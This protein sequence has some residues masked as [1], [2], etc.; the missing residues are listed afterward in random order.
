MKKTLGIIL[1]I[2]T[3]TVGI[4]LTSCATGST[5]TKEDRV[6]LNQ[7]IGETEKIYV[8]YELGEYTGGSPEA[9]KVYGVVPDEASRLA[10]VVADNVREA[11]PDKQVI[12]AERGTVETENNV[13][14]FVDISA[15]LSYPMSFFR[16]ICSVYTQDGGWFKEE[17]EGHAVY[18]GLDE[19]YWD[20]SLAEL[21]SL[22]DK[23]SRSYIRKIQKTA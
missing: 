20:D 18:L 23:K 16:T 19:K 7:Q 8:L 15:L 2:L 4:V 3:G 1:L 10:Q 6:T 13:A 22:V 12:V 5:L 11:W 9:P 21:E 17:S 14:I